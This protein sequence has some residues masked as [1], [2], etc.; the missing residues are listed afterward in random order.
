[1]ANE[2]RIKKTV[3]NKE[4]FKKVVDNEFKTFIQP[5]VLDSDLTIEE[6]FEA[7][8]KLYYELPLEG[9]DSHTTLIVESSK[10][11]EFEKDTENIQPLLDEIAVLREQ[12]NELNKQL[13]DLEQA[14]LVR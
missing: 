10:L 2:V 1:M 14:Q 4:Q 12:N 11:V 8:R 5:I 13:L 7:Y 6:F 9:D 3:Y